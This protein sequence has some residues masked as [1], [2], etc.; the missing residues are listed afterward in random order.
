VL[1]IGFYDVLFVALIPDFALPR[2]G[3][4]LGKEE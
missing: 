1:R 2:E 3:R 4:V